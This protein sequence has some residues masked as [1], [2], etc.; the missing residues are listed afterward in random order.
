[1]IKRFKLF[2]IILFLLSFL[3][4]FQLAVIPVHAVVTSDGGGSGSSGGANAGVGQIDPGKLGVPT[5]IDTIISSVVQ[6]AYAVAGLVFFFMLLFGGIRYLSA[7]GDEKAASAAR[8]T[9][10]NA[11]IGLII[12]VAAFLITQLLFSIF[13]LPGIKFK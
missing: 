6:L 9:L 13:K 4:T 2:K 10:T 3:L 1:M 11:F 8:G 7:G 5:Q 12:V